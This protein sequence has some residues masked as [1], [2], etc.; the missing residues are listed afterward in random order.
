MRESTRRQSHSPRHRPRR[1]LIAERLERRLLLAGDVITDYQVFDINQTGPP[2]V[3]EFFEFDSKLYYRD[4]TPETGAELF[5]LDLTSGTASLV[6]DINPGAG[7]SQVGEFGG[8]VGLGTK[9]YFSA[10]DAAHG[11]EL[12]VL[13]TTDN[14]IE[15]IDIN[16]GVGSSNPGEHGGFFVLNSKL[17]FSAFDPSVGSELRIFDM[18]DQSIQ[19]VDINPGGESSFFDRNGGFA[20]IGDDLYFSARDA[21]VGQELRV[22]DTTDLSLTTFDIHPGVNFNFFPNSSNAGRDSGLVVV[23]DQLYFN[24][25]SPTENSL[26]VLDTSDGSLLSLGVRVNVAPGVTLQLNGTD[27][28]FTGR[29]DTFGSEPRIVDTADNSVTT[30]DV[31]PGSSSSNSGSRG[32]FPIGS[33]LYFVKPS[34][35]SSGD[36]LLSYDLNTQTITELATYLFPGSF[37]QAP[38]RNPDNL[39]VA[40]DKLYFTAF[41]FTSG[42]EWHVLDSADNSITKYDL[43]PGLN[44]AGLGNSSNAG[45]YG[46]FSV[47]GDDVYFAAADAGGYA[48]FQSDVTHSITRLV[49]IYAGGNG[50]DPGTYGGFAAIGD[51]AY[52]FAYDPANNVELRAID[53][54]DGTVTTYDLR[55]GPTP[56][57]TPQGSH[58]VAVGNKLF[59]AAED[60]T[61]GRELRVLDTDTG[62]L[63][64]VDINPGPGDSSIDVGEE[65]LLVGNELYFIAF[66]DSNGQALR[67]VNANDLTLRTYNL[68]SDSGPVT[69]GELHLALGTQLV[70]DVNDPGLGAEIGIFDVADESYRTID[71][72]PGPGGSDSRRLGGV[73]GYAGR[74]YLTANSGQGSSLE[75]HVIDT[76]TDEVQFIDISP[77]RS[78]PSNYVGIGD[79]IYFADR[80]ARIL[81]L[82]TID[83]SLSE[84]VGMADS[85]DQLTRIGTD[86]FFVSG[87]GLGGNHEELWKLDT[88]DDSLT[89]YDI[90]PGQF[91]GSDPFDLTAINGLLYFSALTEETGFEPM[92]LNPMTGKI[93]VLEMAPGATSSQRDESSGVGRSA[94]GFAG[95]G[96]AVVFEAAVPHRGRELVA[97]R[98]LDAN[99]CLAFG[100]VVQTDEDVTISCR[101]FPSGQGPLPT[102]IGVADTLDNAGL[103][104]GAANVG[105]PIAL[106]RGELTLTADGTLA[107]V[108]LPNENGRDAFAFIVDNGDGTTREFSVFVDIDQVNDPGLF[109]GDLAVHAPSLSILTGQVTFSDPLDGDSD[110]NFTV[111]EFDVPA[112]GRAV[113]DPDTGVFL[114][115]PDLGFS[116]LDSFTVVVTDDDGNQEQQVVYVG[117]GTLEAGAPIFDSSQWVPWF[118][119]FI[120][121]GFNDGAAA[122]YRLPEGASDSLPWVGIDR[123]RLPF[124]LEVGDSLDPGDFELEGA[125]GMDAEATATLAP[126]IVDVTWDGSTRL[127]TLH[128]DAGLGPGEFTLT[129][130]AAGIESLA[131]QQLSAD[132]STTFLVL[133][134]DAVDQS[135]QFFGVYGVNEVDLAFI[136]ERRS[137]FLIDLPGN[138]PWDGSYFDYDPRADI[139][140]D[141]W[142]NGFDATL[143]R[144][145]QLG[146]YVMNVA[147]SLQRWIESRP[148]PQPR[149]SLLV[150]PVDGAVPET[151]KV[152]GF[153]NAPSST[154]ASGGSAAPLKLGGGAKR[155][156]DV[157]AALADPALLGD[158]A[159]DDLSLS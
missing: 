108:P 57:F 70:L 22:L 39:V 114:Y 85:P 157:D 51:K 14:S 49:D 83:D 92:V 93:V 145:N 36:Q 143:V 130:F 152:A 31:T 153:S 137:G 26:H 113:I 1:R 43:F 120:D 10:Y 116:G 18:T 97:I 118:R 144:D 33:K 91:E 63:T 90:N 73:F 74:I 158:H 125:W 52:F 69:V 154:E 149:S 84:I 151:A 106:A 19:T 121:G 50:S 48:I 16:P 23:G 34:F 66:D 139:N 150:Q 65:M 60:G 42:N 17:Y 45:R 119:D 147:R 140:G 7:S 142:V 78:F 95:V 6:A 112:N 117:I 136:R 89:P 134:G 29:D 37:A 81:V 126:Q 122:G 103:P 32:I 127:A 82:D 102:V 98:G 54:G 75:L 9:L 8:F 71:I 124:N 56:Q 138:S 80:L 123:I 111:A 100:N 105:V 46:G 104:A 88:L 87:I 101:L 61:V 76:A 3:Q 68:V 62:S 58:V 159:L 53:L 47:V 59:F 131:G 86:I 40:G 109:G 27:L 15:V 35:G 133:P 12:R 156:A 148:A 96:D 79:K 72:M 2:A 67:S 11:F 55:P 20:A 64:T 110:P 30:I 129:A 115:L 4:V 77:G 99:Q 107:Y 41:D 5:A 44:D 132:Q 13:D 25:E 128:L 21:T 141:G 24:A 135:E 146:S 28:L 38:P 155:A 94:G